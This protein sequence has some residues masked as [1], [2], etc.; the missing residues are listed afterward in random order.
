MAR[1]NAEEVRERFI[2]G[3]AT[4]L[5][6]ADALV[7]AF[8]AEAEMARQ[9]FAVR[10]A[11]LALS[12]ALDAQRADVP[13]AVAL[14]SRSANPVLSRNDGRSTSTTPVRTSGE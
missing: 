9:G 11:H 12:R 10:I 8:E 7:S 4:G 3:L 6:Q 13:R 2:H 1:Q 14:A 5:E